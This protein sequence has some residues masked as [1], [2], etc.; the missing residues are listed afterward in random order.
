MVVN[1]LVT[2][3]ERG[4]AKE[5]RTISILRRRGALWVQRSYGSK[6][7]FDV[8]ALFPDRSVYIQVKS[9]KTKAVIS[10]EE[11]KV[12][13][14]FARKITTPNIHIEIWMYH[15]RKKPRIKRLT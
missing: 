7:I 10:E 8:F 3:Y 6:G 2:N 1:L 11:V 13:K 12:L 15:G 5:Y 14:E 9:S 4:R